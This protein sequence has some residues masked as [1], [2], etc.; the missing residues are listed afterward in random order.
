[1]ATV[2]YKG[3]FYGVTA[4]EIERVFAAGKPVVIVVEPGGMKQI[5]RYAA[6]RG[7]DAYSVFVN[8]PAVVI[9]ERFLKR[10]ADDF[11]FEQGP[12][13]SKKI[14]TYSARLTAMMGEEQ[15]WV[16]HAT[17]SDDYDICLAE[18][19][20][21]NSGDVVELICAIVVSQRE[22]A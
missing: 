1:L 18:F 7:W 6:T 10:F 21:K 9:A 12:R 20:E 11:T 2:E 22:T 14:E 19:D 4:A 5:R 8:N 15:K 13:A 16:L 3:A 17:C